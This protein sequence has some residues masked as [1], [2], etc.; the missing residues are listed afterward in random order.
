MRGDLIAQEVFIRLFLSGLLFVPDHDLD[1]RSVSARRV[2]CFPRQSPWSPPRRPAYGQ[3]R[4]S[5]T[6][7]A[8]LAV[9]SNAHAASPWFFAYFDE[10]CPQSR[11]AE[12]LTEGDHGPIKLHL[13]RAESEI[14]RWDMKG[15]VTFKHRYLSGMHCRAAGSGHV[16]THPA[17]RARPAVPLQ[18]A[19]VVTSPSPPPNPSRPASPSDRWHRIRFGSRLFPRRTRKSCGA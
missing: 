7:S 14:R 8:V 1:P 9:F 2:G 12:I 15:Q 19:Y 5:P 10:L 17:D 18:I 16:I 6:S 3:R 13:S 11:R 4:P